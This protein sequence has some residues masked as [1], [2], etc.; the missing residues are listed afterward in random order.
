MF[1]YK[2]SGLN[3]RSSLALPGVPVRN[4]VDGTFDVSIRLGRLPV[5]L[6]DPREVDCYHPVEQGVFLLTVPDV[7]RYLIRHG[8]EILVERAGGAAEGDVRIFLLGGAFGVLCHQ[9]GLLPLHASAVRVGNGCA[10]FLGSSGAGKSTLAALLARR[11]YPLICDDVC[12][13][14][15]F[16]NRAL[17]AYPGF[18]QFKLWQ[19]SLQALQ[20]DSRSLCRCHSREDK[21]YLPAETGFE[22][23]PLPLRQLYVLQEGASASQ[24]RIEWIK[25]FN[26]VTA[27]AANT[28]LADSIEHMGLVMQHFQLCAAVAKAVEVYRFIRPLGFEYMD[29]SVAQLEAYFEAHWEKHDSVGQGALHAV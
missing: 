24:R 15:H 10:A 28:Y 23:K 4:E 13:I 7:A 16:P 22:G 27:L 26:A 14:R 9:R 25:G 3:I 1:D 19:S 29:D 18:P 21:Y 2:L 8:R 17:L 12:V 6:P 20:Q 5:I 11:G